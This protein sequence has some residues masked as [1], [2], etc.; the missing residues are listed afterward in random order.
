VPVRYRWSVQKL[1]TGLDYSVLDLDGLSY[2]RDD[3]A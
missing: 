1:A 2:V 3:G